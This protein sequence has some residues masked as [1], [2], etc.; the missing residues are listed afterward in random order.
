MIKEKYFIDIKGIGNLDIEEVICEYDFPVLFTLINE[1]SRQR[2]IAVCC[3]VVN[4]QRWIIVPISVNDILKLLTDKI[5]IYTAFTS[6][7]EAD[8]IVAH[9]SNLTK[10]TTYDYIKCYGIPKDDFPLENE[11]LE[12]EDG[13]FDD[14][15][16]K[17]QD[18]ELF[19]ISFNYVITPICNTNRVLTYCNHIRSMIQELISYD[20]FENRF[21]SLNC[22]IKDGF[23]NN[24]SIRFNNDN[25]NVFSKKEKLISINI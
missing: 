4:E 24:K 20:I 7:K 8:C 17:L 1:I 11:F 9:W 21:M 2:Y 19:E 13:E 23:S 3:E 12:A 18:K 22:D 16:R 6:N 15:I 14:Y 10:T 25:N 5:D